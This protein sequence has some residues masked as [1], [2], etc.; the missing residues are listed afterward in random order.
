[1]KN[2]IILPYN[3]DEFTLKISTNEY[4][5]LHA[6]HKKHKKAYDSEN[7]MFET[8]N[9]YNNIINTNNSV[10]QN[11]RKNLKND[12]RCK[13]NNH[14]FSTINDYWEKRES[15]NK[16]KMEEIKKEREKKIYG[17][18]YPIPKINK[19]T[20]KIIKRIKIQ[21]NNQISEE[22]K[23][24]DQ[25]NYNI[26][27]KTEQ[28]I[29]FHNI[30]NEINNINCYSK[31]ES[32]GSY[33]NLMKLKTNKKRTITPKNKTQNLNTLNKNKIQN[34]YNKKKKILN[35]IE[36]K[37]LEKIAKLRKAQEE[38]RI[39]KNKAKTNICLTKSNDNF[40]NK[41]KYKKN[42]KK[43]RIQ[44]EIN[45]RNNYK[46]N[47]ML[48][49]KTTTLNNYRIH[50]PTYKDKMSFL[51]KQRKALNKIYNKDKRI[52]NHSYQSYTSRFNTSQTRRTSDQNH[53][54]I[55]YKNNIYNTQPCQE[56]SKITN[57]FSKDN[58]KCYM[59]KN[60][61]KNHI[62]NITNKNRFY[63]NRNF[64][65][66]SKIANYNSYNKPK[67]QHINLIRN[68]NLFKNNNLFYKVSKNNT[69]NS[70]SYEN[71]EDYRNINNLTPTN[72]VMNPDSILGKNNIKN[73][74]EH[75]KTFF[76]NES[77]DNIYNV[78]YNDLNKYRKEN[79]KKMHQLNNNKQNGNNKKL[80]PKNL[81]KY[82]EESKNYLNNQ[83]NEYKSLNNQTVKN[84]LNS[85][86]Q[87]I[88][89][90]LNYYNKEL[91]LNKEKKEI[92][93]NNI[94]GRNNFIKNKYFS[95]SEINK[96][97]YDKIWVYDKY[98]FEKNKNIKEDDNNNFDESNDCK[99]SYL[100]YKI[101]NGEIDEEIEMNDDN[102]EER[103]NNK[104]LGYFNFQRKHKF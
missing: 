67:L 99:N 71:K 7:K 51:I 64:T 37:S 97:N 33:R 90:S 34:N 59:K 103:N 11:Q 56:Y 14:F 53:I 28:N 96:T 17:N 2:E 85:E 92:L 55:F 25:I 47:N 24:E 10:T 39:K 13:N 65:E 38:E 35:M 75:K 66:N 95:N 27:I 93:F 45:S 43:E 79:E 31:F 22:D 83:S 5:K 6:D 73:N 15:K 40:N 23:I 100:F 20:K 68:R 101:G 44:T 77:I 89:N 63:T 21:L 32:Q 19:N 12:G 46:E 4:S 80:L 61:K 36:I 58:A 98:I 1:M 91:E 16:I 62:K 102:Y 78:F 49:M 82:N 54:K 52:I 29:Y 74:N 76:K 9:N 41:H 84:I 8:D 72:V 81:M 70:Y 69:L 42:I 3:N 50:S 94:Y 18:N 26:P 87:I 88:E 57:S 60:N 104:I 30:N 48:K 86:Q